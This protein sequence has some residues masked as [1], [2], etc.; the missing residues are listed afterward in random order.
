L[1]QCVIAPVTQSEPV[2]VEVEVSLSDSQEDGVCTILGSVDGSSSDAFDSFEVSSDLQQG[3]WYNEYVDVH[4][5]ICWEPDVAKSL[6]DGDLD[7]LNGNEDSYDETLMSTGSESR[8]PNRKFGSKTKSP[9]DGSARLIANVSTTVP[10]GKEDISLHIFTTMNLSLMNQNLG[11]K[12]SSE[13]RVLNGSSQT[14]KSGGSINRKGTVEHKSG[15]QTTI[16][17][18]KVKDY[19]ALGVLDAANISLA[20]LG[21]NQLASQTQEFSITRDLD[22]NASFI[23]DF[24]VIG[25][26]KHSTFGSIFTKD[27][28]P[29]AKKDIISNSRFVSVDVVRKR[30]D[31][32][33]GE[34]EIIASSIQKN[35]NSLL[36]KR[37]KT[38]RDEN[39]EDGLILGSISELN[40]GTNEI[41]TFT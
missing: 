29:G 4:V 35:N 24:D 41:R 20:P 22:G 2:Q 40:M 16:S 3:A 37:I 11:T 7:V 31:V 17:N 36:E 30:I 28:S 34:E 27:L 18:I 21:S 9:I 10:A 12:F 13:R 23:Y 6:A 1:G 26:L 19:S 8:S 38:I 14:I 32:V 33:T 25:A 39:N 5:I 15:G